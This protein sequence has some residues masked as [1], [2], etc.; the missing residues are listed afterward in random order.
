MIKK[1]KVGGGYGNRAAHIYCVITEGQSKILQYHF[2]FWWGRLPSSRQYFID[3][4]I[5]EI[6]YKYQYFPCVSDY[7]FLQC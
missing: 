7:I 4:N 5:F 1:E 2:T 3:I 6:P